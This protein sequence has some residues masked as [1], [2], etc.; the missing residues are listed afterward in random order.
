MPRPRP[1]AKAAAFQNGAFDTGGEFL[2][3]VEM[4]ANEHTVIFGSP[5]DQSCEFGETPGT[6]RVN[7]CEMV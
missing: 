5:S 1:A 6:V 2:I 4:D 7:H 3:W